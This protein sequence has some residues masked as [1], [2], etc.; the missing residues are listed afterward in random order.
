MLLFCF[1]N[2]STAKHREVQLV[3]A[4]FVFAQFVFAF[5]QFKARRFDLENAV[6]KQ[7]SEGSMCV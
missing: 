3:F 6:S 4:Q 1:D 5:A 2:K 7:F